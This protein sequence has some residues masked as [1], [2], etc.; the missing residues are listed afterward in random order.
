MMSERSE[1]IR[2]KAKIIKTILLIVSI[3]TFG[4]IGYTGASI[5]SI[6]KTDV[7]ID[8]DT[9]WTYNNG[10]TPLIYSDDTI[11]MS[12]NLSVGNGGF[13]DIEYVKANIEVYQHSTDDPFPP[14]DP[15]LGDG[16]ETFTTI[17][18]GT[19]ENETFT[20]NM[21]LDAAMAESLLLFEG[22]LRFEFDIQ[23]KIQLF[24]INISG[25]FFEDWDPSAL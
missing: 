15:F 2:K 11:D 16:S 22:V 1:K 9:E 3:A 5:Y 23:T 4:M 25:H 18:P 10:G 20:I 8:D 17:V 7:L 14:A 24:P 21:P 13:F 19:Y 12:M 6:V